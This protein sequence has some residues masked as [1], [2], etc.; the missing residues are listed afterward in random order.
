M[1]RD[2]SRCAL[3]SQYLRKPGVTHNRQ[4]IFLPVAL[5]TEI[6]QTAQ[7]EVRI[8]SETRKT[9][10]RRAVREGGAGVRE[11]EEQDGTG[12][13]YAAGIFEAGRAL[14]AALHRT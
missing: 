12:S 1:N 9:D 7:I 3:S 13:I 10:D 2:Y 6:S 11:T 14:E 4:V 8:D 5:A